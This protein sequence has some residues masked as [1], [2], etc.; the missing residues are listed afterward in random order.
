MGGDLLIEGML[1]E[2][3]PV[4]VLTLGIEHFSD[5]IFVATDRQSEGALQVMEVLL[6]P[7]K[8]E[9]PGVGHR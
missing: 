4:V 6:C 7:L 8:L 9:T 5:R 1:G 3:Q 2:S